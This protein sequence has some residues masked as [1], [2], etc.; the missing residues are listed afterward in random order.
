MHGV[1]ALGY[2]QHLRFKAWVADVSLWLVFS[3]CTGRCRMSK[4]RDTSVSSIDSI[5][6]PIMLVYLFSN[7]KDRLHIYT[8]IIL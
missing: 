6:P 4:S 7:E 5:D 8:G 1:I 3:D 2:R